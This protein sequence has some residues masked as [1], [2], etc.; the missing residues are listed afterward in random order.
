MKIG[1]ILDVLVEGI[2]NHKITDSLTFLYAKTGSNVLRPP[3]LKF[4]TCLE[5]GF[6]Y[7]K[8]R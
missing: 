2:N 6:Y 4:S 1:N 5:G 7:N 8:E 3:E